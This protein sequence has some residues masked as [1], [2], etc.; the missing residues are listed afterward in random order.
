MPNGTVTLGLRGSIARLR[1]VS[2]APRGSRVDSLSGAGHSSKIQ[3][4]RR[5]VARCGNMSLVGAS[6]CWK[7]RHE[8]TF[9]IGVAGGL[10]G[11]EFSSESQ[12]LAALGDGKGFL[13]MRDR[14]K[15]RVDYHIKGIIERLDEVLEKVTPK[16]EESAE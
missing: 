8:K 7:D 15:D 2:S 4:G 16:R 1:T 9:D 11:V 12:R 6:T 13:L 3:G 14:Q 5:S 10:C